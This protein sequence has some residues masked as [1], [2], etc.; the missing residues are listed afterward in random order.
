MLLQLLPGLVG[1]F[2]SID[3]ACSDVLFTKIRIR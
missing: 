3:M 1:V 2:L